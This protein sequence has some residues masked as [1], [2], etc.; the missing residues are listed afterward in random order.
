M[1]E[2]YDKTS[3]MLLCDEIGSIKPIIQFWI[4]KGDSFKYRLY[5]FRCGPIL[6]FQIDSSVGRIP[7][8]ITNGQPKLSLFCSLECI[9]FRVSIFQNRCFSLRVL[10]ALFKKYYWLKMHFVFLRF[11]NSKRHYIPRIR[12]QSRWTILIHEQN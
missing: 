3:C 5:I 6:S 8:Y 2:V 10:P 7:R 4:A 1:E 11:I 9:I 12:T